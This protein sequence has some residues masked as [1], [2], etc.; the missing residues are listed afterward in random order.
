[1]D[2]TRKELIF[3]LALKLANQ[4]KDFSKKNEHCMNQWHKD[5]DYTWFNVLKLKAD[6]DEEDLFLNTIKKQLKIINDFRGE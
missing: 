4:R 3:N 1:M 6:S 5:V 2:N